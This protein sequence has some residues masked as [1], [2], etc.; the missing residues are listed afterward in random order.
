MGQQPQPPQPVDTTC[1]SLLRELQ[2][3]FPSSFDYGF[4]LPFLG[5]Q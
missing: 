3:F 5:L 1:G 2:V 4:V